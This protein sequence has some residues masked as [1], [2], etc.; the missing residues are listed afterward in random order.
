MNTLIEPS[1]PHSLLIA[2]RQGQPEAWNRFVHLYGPLVY[3]WIRRSGFQ[4]SD[5]ADVTQD[6][7]MSVSKDLASFDPSRADAKFRGWL[8]TITRR[9]IA[10]FCR[11]RPTEHEL[12][13]G[14]DRLPS[15][16]LSHDPPT[17]ADLDRQTLLT[18]AVAIYRDRF[19][20]KTWQAFWATVVEGREPDEVAQSLGVTRWTVYKARARIL[21][22][23][24]TELAGL[25][26]V[27]N[28]SRRN[29]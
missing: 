26:D 18:Q 9:R 16:E 22:R 24:R 17:D 11:N 27:S 15:P 13:S 2:A 29:G 14:A 8:W 25:I 28:P 1:T 21:Q 12:G 6:V 10:D 4:S 20:P 7:L 5:A 3:R 23:L 19:D